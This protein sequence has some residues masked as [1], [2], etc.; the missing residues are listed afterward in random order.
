MAASAWASA[1]ASGS[2]SGR[3]AVGSLHAAWPDSLSYNAAVKT[4][5]RALGEAVDELEARLQGA[6]A[7]H[8]GGGDGSRETVR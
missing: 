5:R 1:S 4:A 6:E 2:G 8:G 7:A 3:E